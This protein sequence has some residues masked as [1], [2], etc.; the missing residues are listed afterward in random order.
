MNE[1]WFHCMNSPKVPDSAK[2]RPQSCSTCGSNSTSTLRSTW[3]T[4]FSSA[5][6]CQKYFFALSIVCFG[7]YQR[8]IWWSFRLLICSVLIIHLT[9]SDMD[10]SSSYTPSKPRC[11]YHVT[12]H[13]SVSQAYHVRKHVESIYARVTW[14]IDSNTDLILGPLHG[15]QDVIELCPEDISMMLSPGGDMQSTSHRTTQNNHRIYEWYSP[16]P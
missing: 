14:C 8:K 6:L 3:S 13:S 10:L 5:E 15:F 7:V 16:T 9:T 1:R 4:I 11:C 2:L 12:E